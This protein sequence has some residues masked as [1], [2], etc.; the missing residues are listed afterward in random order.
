MQV[1]QGVMHEFDNTMSP[2]E[3][4]IVSQFDEQPVD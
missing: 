2:E 1:S 3:S 4:R